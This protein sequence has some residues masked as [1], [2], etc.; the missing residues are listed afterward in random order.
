LNEFAPPRQLNRYAAIDMRQRT[1]ILSLAVCLIAC[2]SIRSQTPQT[3]ESYEAAI[4]AIAANSGA[5][6]VAKA[7]ATL[8]RAGTKAFPAL[9][10]HLND[11][12][13]AFEVFQHE[14]QDVY[15][16][17]PSPTM[18]DA[19]FDLVQ[20][21]I[22]G[23]WP[24]GLRQYYVLSRTN[25]V[26]WWYARKEKS[27]KDLRIEAALTSLTMARRRRGTSRYDPGERSDFLKSIFERRELAGMI[28]KHVRRITNRWTRAAGAPLATSLVR[29]RVL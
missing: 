4:T 7:I 19:C 26:S 24:K 20:G 27:L 15:G 6:R 3:D 22:E 11:T 18:G 25:I 17:V 23:N 9:L 28:G 5:Q 12:T 1:F 14:V 21:Q 10:A 29:Q 13:T 2:G 16:N 8:E